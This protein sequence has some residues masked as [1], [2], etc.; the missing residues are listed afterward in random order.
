[1]FTS[2]LLTNSISHEGKHLTYVQFITKFTCVAKD[3]RRKPG[4]GG[5]T[6]GRLNWMPLSTGEL[7]YL[8]NWQEPQRYASLKALVCYHSL[9]L[10]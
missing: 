7:Y 3:K 5:Y 9:N 10:C 2:W 1:M 8:R 6:I 4:K